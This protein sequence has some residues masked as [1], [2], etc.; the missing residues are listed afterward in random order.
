MSNELPPKHEST[1]TT[2]DMKEHR[3]TNDNLR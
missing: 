1:R 2:G 3:T